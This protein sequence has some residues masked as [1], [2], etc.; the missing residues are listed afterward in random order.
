MLWNQSNKIGFRRVIPSLLRIKYEMEFNISTRLH[1]T[2]VVYTYGPYAKMPR[3]TTKIHMNGMLWVSN[4]YDCLYF[5]YKYKTEH[6]TQ[7]PEVRFVHI[8]M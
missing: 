8:L 7:V 2:T 1:T 6:K 5:I 4:V 3:C